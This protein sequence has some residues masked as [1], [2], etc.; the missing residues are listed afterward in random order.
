MMAKLAGLWAGAVGCGLGLG[1]QT[2]LLYVV[3]IMYDII[4]KYSYI[5]SAAALV[6]CGQETNKT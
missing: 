3:L 2:Q 6:R 5:S 1:G 4:K